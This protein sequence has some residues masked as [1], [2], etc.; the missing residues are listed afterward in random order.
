MRLF[1]LVSGIF[2]S[3]TLTIIDFMV[4]VFFESFSP[5]LSGLLFF[6][7]IH[8]FFGFF[9]CPSLVIECP[10]LQKYEHAQRE[11]VWPLFTPLSGSK[12]GIKH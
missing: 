8:G 4:Q 3:V 11:H 5:P 12:I 2:F 9:F 7:V 10:L 6:R 1:G